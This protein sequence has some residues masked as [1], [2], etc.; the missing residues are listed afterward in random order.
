[1]KAV[2]I[3]GNDRFELAFLFPLCQFIVGLVGLDSG[4]QQFILVITEE[5]LRHGSVA[6]MTE[7]ELRRIFIFLPVQ[8]VLTSEIRNSAFRGDT[9][10]TEKDN[11]IRPRYDLPEL[12]DLFLVSHDFPLWRRRAGGPAWAPFSFLF[13]TFSN[14]YGWFSD[15][16]SQPRGLLFLILYYTIKQPSIESSGIS[17]PG[18]EPGGVH[19]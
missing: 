7:H 3:L 1:M 6:G 9:G 10:S 4:H 18:R 5:L 14:S 17:A 2:Y 8:A 12:L 11:V 16:L 15:C 19:Q 13:T